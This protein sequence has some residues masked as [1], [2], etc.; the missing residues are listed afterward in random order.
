MQAPTA[1]LNPRDEPTKETDAQ[2]TQ[3]KRKRDS[4]NLEKVVSEPS[5]PDYFP[6]S[7]EHSLGPLP[8]PPSQYRGKHVFPHNL[9]FRTADWVKDEIP[10]DSEGYDVVIACVDHPHDFYIDS[11]IHGPGFQSR[12]GYISTGVTRGSG[13]SSVAFTRF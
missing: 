11:N 13:L 12:N 7:F 10:E 3:K 6:A 9:S 1:G 2:A 4:S 8:I 5:Q